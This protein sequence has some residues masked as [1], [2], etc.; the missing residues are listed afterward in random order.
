MNRFLAIFAVLAI[1]LSGCEQVQ[2]VDSR[3]I[4]NFDAEV[5]D[6]IYNSSA[7]VNFWI[8]NSLPDTFNLSQDLSDVG[9]YLNN[10]DISSFSVNP[11]QIK[12]GE[13]NITVAIRVNR[14]KLMNWWLSNENVSGNFTIE[15]RSDIAF[16]FH[17]AILRILYQ[18][19][20]SL[21]I[22]HPPEFTHNR[23]EFSIMSIS[24]WGNIT[25]KSTEIT[26]HF[27]MKPCGEMELTRCSLSVGGVEV[28]ENCSMN[29]VS[30]CEFKVL[31]FIN[32]TKL[33][34]VLANSLLK[35][36]KFRYEVDLIVNGSNLSLISE[37]VSRTVFE[38][39]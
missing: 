22:P 34:D 35:G 4:K 19:T 24:E 27:R 11:G 30:S 23:N 29:A 18:K 39:G 17:N 7:E 5:V 21:F 37:K 38:E 14:T 36:S 1:L 12:P 32:N 28:T 6:E 8:V 20:G 26:Y 3:E 33:I 2:N 31:Q 10:F 16:N 13:N 15:L 25:N 9:I